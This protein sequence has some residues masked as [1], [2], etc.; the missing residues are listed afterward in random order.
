MSSLYSIVV[1][2]DNEY[3]NS[4]ISEA[5]KQFVLSDRRIKG[6]PYSFY[7]FTNAGECVSLI[8]SGEFSG[9]ELIGFIDYYLGEGIT[10]MHIIKV[11]KDYLSDSEIIMLSNSTDVKGRTDNNLIDHFVYKDMSAPSLCCR[12]LD[13]YLERRFLVNLG[14]D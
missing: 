6:I 11:L 9:K 5:L 13:Q 1:V 3:Y 4:L 2:E 8:R 14:K 10:G 7:S 12:Y